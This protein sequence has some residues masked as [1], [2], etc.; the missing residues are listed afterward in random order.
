M[1]FIEIESHNVV[2]RGKEEAS[3]GEFGFRG[4]EFQPGKVDKSWR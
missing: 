2:T 4:T 1:K 3:N